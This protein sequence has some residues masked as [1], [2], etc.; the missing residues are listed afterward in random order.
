MFL[1]KYRADSSDDRSPWG[2]FWFEPVGRRTGSGIAVTNDGALQLAAV[3]ACVRVLAE[4]FAVL[5]L[6]VYQKKKGGARKL[7][8]SHW[9][10]DLIARRPNPWQT[11]FE[12]REMMMGHLALRGNA[13]NEIVTNRQGKIIQLTPL[14]PDRVKVELIQGNTDFD[15]RY[16]YT[17][18][19]GTEHVLT[20]GEVWHIRGLSSD[21]IMGLSPIALARETIGLGLAAQA[22]GARFFQN[23]AKPGGGWI[24]YPGTFKDKQARETFRESY[25]EAQSGL[26]RG[27]IA[28]LEYGMKFH[29]LGLKNND[30]QFLESRQFQVGEIAR[31]FR[32]PPHLIGDLSKATFSNI[33]QQSLDFV[34]HTMTPWAERWESSI[35]FN[36]IGD[37]ESDID[38]EFDFKALLR[39]DQTARGNYYHFGI[40]DGW[41][42]RNEA[43][44]FEGLEPIDGLDE[45]LRPLN[46]VEESEAEQQGAGSAPAKPNQ[47]PG[48]DDTNPDAPDDQGNDARMIAL[49]QAAA[50]RVAR[51]EVQMAKLAWR[52]GQEAVVA[53]YAKH[54]VFV[55]GA[56]GV[57]RE[58]AVA[59]CAQQ[60]ADLAADTALDDFENLALCRLE[61]LALKGTL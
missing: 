40:T 24:E 10:Y 33:E 38:P 13:Y 2:D 53:A 48:S 17:D 15:Y 6:K 8:D 14:H 51:K 57:G 9:L 11:P 49:A 56:L 16:R 32:V 39:G 28:V 45:P 60:Q 34:M 43:R 61:R 36:F 44:A 25:Q 5:P 55:A 26:N 54:A 46:M 37:D 29:E 4:S 18:R 41:L 42:V 1:S 50:A 47:L 58:V 7:L 12:W 23:D 52:D 31:I 21:G 59:Y 22:Y 20:R 30:A 3:L 35:E 19:S 27:K